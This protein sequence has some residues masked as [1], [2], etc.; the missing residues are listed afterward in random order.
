MSYELHVG[1]CPNS[2][3]IRA[4]LPTGQTDIHVVRGGPGV[5]AGVVGVPTL[6]CVNAQGQTERAWAGADA[7]KAVREYAAI[8]AQ[9]RTE[10]ARAHAAAGA[11]AIPPA[12]PR[13]HGG[14]DSA[15]VADLPPGPAVSTPP[16]H[17]PRA[18]GKR[19][20]S[21]A[22]GGLM[23]VPEDLVEPPSQGT[24]GSFFSGRN[25]GQAGGDQKAAVACISDSR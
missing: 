21:A 8:A 13:A 4:L 6:V 10:D 14:A 2:N 17:A 12:E 18:A 11:A 5:R 16:T 23:Q 1:T 25:Y 7:F 3:R 15:D 24:E 19:G 22:F 9:R 20:K